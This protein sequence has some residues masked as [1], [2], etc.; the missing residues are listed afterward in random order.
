MDAV[1]R[2]LR[3]AHIEGT[4]G[5][6]CRTAGQF[7]L[8]RAAPGPGHAPFLL[9]VEGRCTVSTCASTVDLG[10]GDLLLLPHGDAH[11]VCVATGPRRPFVEEVGPVFTTRR[12]VGVEPELD[13]YLGHYRVNSATGTLLFRTLP[14]LVHVTLG[15]SGAGLADVL[16]GGARFDRLGTESLVR[17]L[18]DALLDIALR[19][20]PEQRLDTP[21]LWTAV[22]DD[23]LGKVIAGI[24]ERP[25]EPWTI[26]RM[27]TAASMSRATFLRRFT[28]R[29]GTTVASLLTTIRMMAA[30]DLLTRSDHS[31]SHI[32]RQVGY[33]SESAFAQAFR[34]AVGTQPARFRKEVGARR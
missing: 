12:S 6:R 3:S 26:E 34:A 5:L 7:T 23:T 27:A 16:R 10:P 15:V 19:S 31:V 2:L 14:P 8:D 22:G 32:A 17:F 11:Q 9:V 18:F 29:T 13:L 25:G 20:R 24:V 4:L 21:A 28:A 33:S 30:A 1:S